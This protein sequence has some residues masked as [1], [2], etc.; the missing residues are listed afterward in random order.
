MP[1]VGVIFNPNAKR[2]K[3][4]PDRLK[5]MAFIIGEKASG[6]PTQ[7]LTDLDVVADEFK[8]K[9]IDILA[10]SGGD[11][12]IH[13]TLTAFLKVYGDKPLPKIALLRGGTQNNIANVYKIKG[14]TE[15]LLSDLLLKYHESPDSFKQRKLRLL[16][17]NDIFGTIFGMGGGYNYMDYYYQYPNLNK[18]AAIRAALNLGLSGLVHG[19]LSRRIMERIDC[20]VEVDGKIWSFANY[21]LLVASTI[22]MPGLDM[23]LFYKM[24]N[25]NEKFHMMGFSCLPRSL[26]P[27]LPR[28][29][30]GKGPQSEFVLED[31]ALDVTMKFERPVGYTVDGDMLEPAD[32]IRLKQGPE[33]TLLV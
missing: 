16:N 33:L 31:L 17:V 30:R 24:F 2:Y 13:C 22:P 12:T 23:P 28:V 1:G 8:T 10:I 4:N 5:R 20:E 32:V 11:G 7:D 6:K 14:Q 15:A 19:P 25:Q 29:F 18:W 9:D 21:C 3:K 27:M 26:L